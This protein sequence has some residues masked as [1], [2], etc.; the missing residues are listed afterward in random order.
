ML[1]RILYVGRSNHSFSDQPAQP[2]LSSFGY[3]TEWLPNWPYELGTNHHTESDRDQCEGHV[4]DCFHSRLTIV[5]GQLGE[6]NQAQRAGYQ[7]PKSGQ[8]RDEC[9]RRTWSSLDPVSDR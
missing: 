7:Q 2:P 8:E 6:A 3:F 1:C 5:G 4:A 9:G